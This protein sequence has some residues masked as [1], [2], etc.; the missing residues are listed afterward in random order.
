MLFMLGLL[1]AATLWLDVSQY[2]ARI[3]IMPAL[4]M[5]LK[6]R[7]KPPWW[8]FSF[9]MVRPRAHGGSYVSVCDTG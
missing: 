5:D 8:V 3:L 1:T 6:L 4:K 7:L 9:P 2:S